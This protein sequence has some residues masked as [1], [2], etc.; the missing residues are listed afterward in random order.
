MRISFLSTTSGFCF[1]GL[2]RMVAIPLTTYEICINVYLT[3][4]FLLPL[5]NI[6]HFEHGSRAANAQLRK[7][8]QRCLIGAAVTCMSTGAN[9]TAVAILEHEEAWLCLLLCN[10]DRRSFL[11]DFDAK[12]DRS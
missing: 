8:T 10:L 2:Q 6:T 12:S 11:G 5:R 1:I 9:L 3:M 7:M 4:L